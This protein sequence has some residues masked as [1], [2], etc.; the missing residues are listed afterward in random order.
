[1]DDESTNKITTAFDWVNG[2]L[3]NSKVLIGILAVGIIVGFGGNR[4]IGYFVDSQTTLQ[5]TKVS[6]RQD[7]FE[8]ETTNRFGL[9]EKKLDDQEV[10]LDQIVD[11]KIQL[12][13]I[14]AQITN[15]SAQVTDVRKA[16][17]PS[18]TGMVHRRTSRNTEPWNSEPIPEISDR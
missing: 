15:V 18:G 9:D 7:R 5:F 6:D 16:L 3:G 4:L 14:Q 11:L 13:V 2:L 17:E 12:A 8:S 10:K 1:M